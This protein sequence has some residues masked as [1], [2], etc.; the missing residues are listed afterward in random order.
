MLKKQKKL[1]IG[2][3]LLSAL[4][5]CGLHPTAASAAISQE[6]A[7]SVCS[8]NT[9]SSSASLSISNSGSAVVSARVIGKAGT[10]KIQMTVK[11]QKYDSKTGNWKAV[12]T[13]E[14]TKMS[15]ILSVEYN[16]SLSARGTYRCK[17]TASVVK[18][19]KSETV[20]LTSDKKKY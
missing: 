20:S 3:L 11:L 19:G 7:V 1:F 10:E 16:Y 17:M 13:W 12:K 2:A 9:A 15:S 5:I 14:K 8:V 6:N 18:A 4:S